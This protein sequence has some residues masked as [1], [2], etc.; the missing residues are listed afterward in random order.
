M[1]ID[2][3]YFNLLFEASELS[4]KDVAELLS[5]DPR[6]I[7]RVIAGEIASNPLHE[8][9]LYW[10]CQNIPPQFDRG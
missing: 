2:N 1:G 4:I 9:V 3:H 10:Y 5:C 8:K 6:R 7:R